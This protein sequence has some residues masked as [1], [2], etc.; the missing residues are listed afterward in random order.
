MILKMC[1]DSSTERVFS[2][3][4]TWLASIEFLTVTAGFGSCSGGGGNVPRYVLTG[5]V[6][7]LLPGHSVV[8]QNYG[9]DS[10]TVSA[11]GSFEF[12]QPF[13][14]GAPYSVTV[15]TQPSGENCTTVNGSGTGTLGPGTQVS[16]ACTTS[17]M[18]SGSVSGSPWGGTAV[19]Q[20]NGGDD[21]TVSLPTVNGVSVPFTFSEALPIGT[22]YTVTILQAPT[23][24]A[25]VFEL[26]GQFNNGGQSSVSGIGTADVTNID[27]QCTGRLFSVGP[28]VS[29]LLPNQSITLK[30]SAGQPPGVYGYP[31]IV[32]GVATANGYCTQ[33]QAEGAP[34]FGYTVAIVSQPAGETCTGA[35]QGT[36]G[37]QNVTVAIVCAASIYTIGGVVSGL[38]GGKTVVLQDNGGNA[39]AVSA[40]GPFTFSTAL[41]NQSPYAVTIVTQ[42]AGQTC[43]VTNGAGAVPAANVTNVAIA[44]TAVKYTIGGTVS[45]LSAGESVVL[46]DNGGNS[47][48]V[49]A[50]GPFTFSTSIPYQSPYAVTVAT[51]PAGER[52]VVTNGS[53]TTPPAN[54]TNVAVTCAVPKE[55]TWQSGSDVPFAAGAYGTIGKATS[56]NVPGAR[57]ALVSWVDSANNLWLF[58][59]AYADASGNV[60]E[61]NDLWEYNQAT[62]LWTWQS[63]ASTLNSAG[64]Y[65]T[66]GAPALTNVPGARA[67]AVSWTDSAGNFW[68]FGGSSGVGVF[69]DL[70]RY[71]PSTG[72]WTWMSGSNSQNAGGVYGTRG[73]AAAGNVPAAR[74]GSVS[75]VDKAGNL[76]LLGGYGLGAANSYLNDLWVYSTSTGLWTWIGGSTGSNAIGVY[77]TLGVAAPG[78]V[79]GARTGAVSWT[80]PTGNF[81]LFGGSN[82]AGAF[83]DLWRYSPTT[84]LWAWI[85]GSNGT[86]ASGVFGTQG[87]GAAGNTPG[88]RYSSMSWTDEAGNLWLLG[89]TVFGGSFQNDLWEYSPS[90][91]LWTWI[92]GSNQQRQVGV[93]GTVGLAAA[94]NIPG[95]RTSSATWVD[96]AGNFWLFGGDAFVSADPS[97][98]GIIND[99]W[100]YVPPA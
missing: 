62:G 38:L 69:N 20:L 17:Y 12:S 63:G 84:G 100:R 39:T 70:W 79:P 68:L 92:G 30:T 50:D 11:N 16:V 4:G 42:P 26:N 58:G 60:G 40:N 44:C 1:D 87:T 23:Y 14:G 6:S 33:C 54:V 85:S 48:T 24:S 89:G 56:G 19:L 71:S 77:G 61:L 72:F 21:L 96:G 81:W 83:N 98:P 86:G 25:C 31:P 37:E 88:A 59:G 65:G 15:L 66:Q 52:C 57:Y 80:D 8:L 2:A 67:D 94:A 55:W 43:S 36:I 93:Y 27:L 28:T 95:A 7:G 5:S 97:Y 32:T 75:W 46:E 49:S 78:N 82:S 51:Q 64:S 3:A 73:T 90:M 47:T 41:A 35:Q 99:L 18:V 53:G 22:P 13:A 76:W 45:G 91:G 34:S 74:Q 10:T 29:G 9:T